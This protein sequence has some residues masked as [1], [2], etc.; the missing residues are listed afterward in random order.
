MWSGRRRRPG[1]YILPWCSTL[2]RASAPSGGSWLRK[3]RTKRFGNR[4]RVH[5]S[6]PRRMR[7]WENSPLKRRAGNASSR[8]RGSLS[9]SRP[10]HPGRVGRYPTRDSAT[11]R[12]RRWLERMDT[13]RRRR[14]LPVS[15]A[16]WFLRD[17]RAA[18]PNL[19]PDTEETLGT[20]MN[21][22]RSDCN[23]VQRLI[24]A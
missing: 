15:D 5:G 20:G 19:I 22:D 9:M 21:G 16:G 17:A 2:V 12:R 23:L 4:R 13:G 3:R 10:H 11:R 18:R 7:A 8:R 14:R 1:V 24:R 6:Q